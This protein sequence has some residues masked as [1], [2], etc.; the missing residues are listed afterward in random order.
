MEQ[1]FG[2][3]LVVDGEYI[4]KYTH[5][6]FDFGVVGATPITFPIEWQR[7]KIPGYAIRVSVPD[8][9]G[10][11]ALVVMSG[12]AARFFLPQV[13]GLPI[14]GPGT[15]VFRIDHDELFNQTTHLQYQPWKKLPWIGFNW[16][17]DSG[18]V[19]GAVPC[20][21]ATAT[22]SPAT[23]IADGG[24]NATVG[25]GV[26]ALVN[27]VTGGPLT[28]DQE[29]QAGLTCNGV[30]AAP[31]PLGPAL[32]TCSAAGLG[33]LYV[34][35]PKPGAENDDHDP[36]RIQPRSLFD[37]AAGDDNLF[38]GDKY[39][40]SLRFTVINVTNKVALYNF[41]STFSGTHYVTP[42]AETIELGFH[43]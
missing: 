1:A 34:K 35:I 19:A 42:R 15:S 30:L 40:W 16:R 10:F 18:L 17:Y 38:H 26:I 24:T 22:C 43:F 25:T 3:Y 11:T 14:I 32:A 31:N 21:A 39:K 6:G 41:L 29:F 4:W 13:A 36:Q 20:L 33:S 23:S 27:A 5:N 9:H 8:F 7:N 12:V 28:A 37:I 2:K